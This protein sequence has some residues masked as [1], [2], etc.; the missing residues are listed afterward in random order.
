MI[1]LCCDTDRQTDNPT[2][3]LIIISSPHQFFRH[4]QWS[5]SVHGRDGATLISEDSAFFFHIQSRPLLSHGS[6][7]TRTCDVRR[8][9]SWWCLVLMMRRA[10]TREPVTS[11][12]ASCV[13][14]SCTAPR[15]RVNSEP[16]LQSNPECAGKSFRSAQMDQEHGTPGS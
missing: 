14:S 8:G 6:C 15:F 13:S 3:S 4:V 1:V 12:N 11:W 9:S 7:G 16:G 2:S 5:S 10:L